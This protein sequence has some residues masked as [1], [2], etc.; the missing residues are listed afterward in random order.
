MVIVGGCLSQFFQYFRLKHQSGTRQHCVYS[1]H[2]NLTQREI[3]SIIILLLLVPLFTTSTSISAEL[4][5]WRGS[6]ST[7]GIIFNTQA[8]A[9]SDFQNFGGLYALMTEPLPVVQQDDTIVIKYKIPDAALMV[10]AWSYGHERKV[11]T[12]AT[13]QE[14]YD[15]L[16]N[17]FIN[18]RQSG[19]P[20]SF[21]PPYFEMDPSGSSLWQTGADSVNA[22]YLSVYGIPKSEDK[23]IPSRF[24]APDT[25]G[26]CRSF[27]AG[28]KRLGRNRSIACPINLTFDLALNLCVN[29]NRATVTGSSQFYL[30]TPPNT[31][32][33]DVEGNPCHPATGNKSQQ[34]T[35]ISNSGFNGLGFARF[36]NS[37]GDHNSSASEAPGWRHTYNRQLNESTLGTPSLYQGNSEQSSL[38][39]TASQA[40][41]NG[42]QEIKNTAWNGVLAGATAT[43][44]SNQDCRIKMA[45]K[46]VANFPIRPTLDRFIPLPQPNPAGNLVTV[47]RP[48]G[49]VYRF[50]N[51]GSIWTDPLSPEVSLTV[52]G[53]DWL[54][55][56]TN[57]TQERYDSTGKLLSITDVRGNIQTL[58]YDANNLLDRV[59]TNTGEFLQFGYDTSNRISTVTDNTERT[60]TY[61]YDAKGNLAFVDN[62]DSTTRQYHYE[63]TNYTFALTGITDER[64]NRYATWAYNVDGKVILSEHAGGAERIN[65]IY[66]PDG[67]TTVTDSRGAS[68][69]YNFEPQRGRLDVT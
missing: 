51:N 66:N 4:L 30:K 15:D 41:I 8:E 60:W 47:S 31:P 10:S 14:A 69:T 21:C 54:F 36:Y 12:F 62:P 55:T 1:Y 26:I 53:S 23:F 38:Y 50:E 24:Y 39:S 42:W 20:G 40:C 25:N 56:D 33:C 19:V 16:L 46:T 28:D 13:E 43:F 61:R 6:P 63:D 49:Q 57:S 27:S 2:F 11:G 67:T 52:N 35:D 7:T 22:I 17:W 68:R 34:Q 3:R 65:L 37:L 9:V 32:S 44:M 64:L 58:T 45:G 59:D 48:D 18:A 29:T 5:L